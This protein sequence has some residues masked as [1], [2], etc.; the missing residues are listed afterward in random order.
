MFDKEDIYDIEDGDI[1]SRKA[2]ELRK[3][4]FI[5]GCNEAYD[6]LKEVGDAVIK[7]ENKLEVKEAINRAIGYFVFEEDYEKCHELKLIYK[8]F[9]GEDPSPIQPNF[10]TYG[11]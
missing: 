8:N 4:R 6:I 10:T 9:Y 5:E 7:E 1:L 2:S 3:K 11:I